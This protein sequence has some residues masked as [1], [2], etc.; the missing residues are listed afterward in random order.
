VAALGLFITWLRH[1]GPQSSGV[2][3]VVGGQVLAGPG[4]ADKSLILPGCV[5]HGASIDWFNPS[6]AHHIA[7]AQA[8]FLS[9]QRHIGLGQQRQDRISRNNRD[10]G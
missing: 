2:E 8:R 4:V 9:A 7:A 5:Q 3:V 1:A 6:I 10:K